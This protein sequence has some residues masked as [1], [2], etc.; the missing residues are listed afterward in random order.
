MRRTTLI[1]GFLLSLSILTTSAIAQKAVAQDNPAPG[2]QKAV[3]APAGSLVTLKDF[4]SEIKDLTKIHLEQSKNEAAAHRNTLDDKIKGWEAVGEKFLWFIALIGASSIVGLY[5]YSRDYARKQARTQIDA[6]FEKELTSNI[7]RISSK[8]HADMEDLVEEHRAVI[9]A[10]FKQSEAQIQVQFEEYEAKLQEIIG[11]EAQAL[12]EDVKSLR[13]DFARVPPDG[14]APQID[15][16]PDSVSG[17]SPQERQKHWEK[18]QH[19]L[20][21]HNFVWRS[22]ERLAKAADVDS[23]L[24]E[25][26]LRDHGE[27]VRISRGKSGRT[28]ARH[29]SRS[30][31]NR[32]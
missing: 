29:I 8:F 7:E 3:P 2:A 18:M 10:Q 11:A 6:V 16:L 27:E 15:V 25:D 22:L 26:I 24:A 30:P 4:M 32:A 20:L 9:E 28:I 5:F 19:A 13:E 12:M 23:T 31:A 1:A 17:N 21:N 14:G